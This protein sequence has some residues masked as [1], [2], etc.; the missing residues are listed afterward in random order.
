MESRKK[1]RSLT[2]DQKT[3]RDDRLFYVSMDDRYA[4]AQYLRFLKVPRV[5]I[6]PLAA[7]T[8]AQSAKLVIERLRQADAL[9]G[10]E[11]WALLDGDHYLKG[12]HLNSFTRALQEARQAGIQVA[13]SNPCFELW[14]LLHWIE[15]EELGPVGS[16]AE[17]ARRLSEVSGGYNKTSLKP[18]RFPLEKL[19]LATERARKMDANV[20]GGD[21][22]QGPTTRV[23]KL[24]D[25][26]RARGDWGV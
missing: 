19:E 5:V 7:G 15:P 11:K 13:I 21:L 20:S 14:L 12:S 2:R 9:E 4:P 23:Y 24:I 22:P 10:D 26:L 18:W 1:V 3:F 8:E 25:A 16:A 17:L 6:I